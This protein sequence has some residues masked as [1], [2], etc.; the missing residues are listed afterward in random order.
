MGFWLGL[1]LYLLFSG[2]NLL[3][4]QLASHESLSPLFIVIAFL[5]G[6]I[7]GRMVLS[8]ILLKDDVK[9]EF[10]LLSFFGLLALFYPYLP[11]EP[12]IL[13]IVLMLCGFGVIRGGATR[14]RT[15]M[16]KIHV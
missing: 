5:L 2:T 11:F 10:A 9:L 7:I 4:K 8:K 3:K 13:A 6:E 1:G 16:E 15:F 14:L 12:K